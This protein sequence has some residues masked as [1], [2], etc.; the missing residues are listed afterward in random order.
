M[1][2]DTLWDGISPGGP[3]VSALTIKWRGAAEALSPSYLGRGV[4]IAKRL[5][6][7]SWVTIDFETT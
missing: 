5:R 2:S 1:S 7:L 4:V 6:P 3:I